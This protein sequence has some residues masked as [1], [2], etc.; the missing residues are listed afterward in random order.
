MRARSTSDLG[1]FKNS[2]YTTKARSSV[3]TIVNSDHQ[4]TVGLH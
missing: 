2:T 4:K 1:L 3:L